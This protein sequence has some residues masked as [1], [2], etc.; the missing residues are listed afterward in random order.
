MFDEIENTRALG[1][2]KLSNKAGIQ[3]IVRFKLDSGAG[4]NL[5]PICVYR[6]LFPNRKLHN[7]I[8][9]RVQL[10][11]ANKTQIK[12]LGTD[13]LRVRVGNKEKPCLFYVKGFRHTR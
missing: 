9:K 11:A 4:A 7:T 8:D 6:K 2:L 3:C 5:L 12:Q 1:D 13:R 10:L